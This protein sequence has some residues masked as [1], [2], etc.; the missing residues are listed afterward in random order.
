MAPQ[1]SP[2]LPPQPIVSRQL[3]A[4][5]PQPT[6]PVVVPSSSHAPEA[7]EGELSENDFHQL[8]D[9]AL[10]W[11]HEKFDALGDEVD[12]EGFDV[13]LSQG[14]LTLRL[15]QHG[16]FVINKQAPNRQIWF[17][18]PQSG[19]ARFDWLPGQGWVYRRTGT[20]LMS[21]LQAELSTCLGAGAVPSLALHRPI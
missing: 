9:E 2:L 3:S 7:T 5:S 18:S 14:V 1:V 17:S 8:A 20:E 11:L 19:P 16:I 10:H 4:S 21:L 13:D 6:S 12:I 15:G